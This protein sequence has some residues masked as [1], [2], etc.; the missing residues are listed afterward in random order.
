MWPEFGYWSQQLSDYPIMTLF[1]ILI[2]KTKNRLGPC[3]QLSEL[4]V[5]CMGPAKLAF[6]SENAQPSNQRTQCLKMVSDFGVRK[7]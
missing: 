6:W 3:N 4:D 5:K 7:T 1:P 2:H